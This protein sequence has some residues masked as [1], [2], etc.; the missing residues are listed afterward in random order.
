MLNALADVENLLTSI[1]VSR[2]RAVL[3]SQILDEAKITA[4]L[5]SAQYIEGE[6]DLQVVLDAEQFLGDAQDA[7]V[8]G[9]QEQLF[10]QIAMYRAM[11][12]YRTPSPPRV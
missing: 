6:E 10:A 3:I 4:D 5:S 2:E 8:L 12:G 1:A 11:G 7:E 9:H